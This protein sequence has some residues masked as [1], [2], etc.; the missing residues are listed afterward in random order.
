MKRNGL[1]NR[2]TTNISRKRVPVSNEQLTWYFDNIE[3][4][5]ILSQESPSV[6]WM[7]KILILPAKKIPFSVVK[8]RQLVM[9]CLLMRMRMMRKPC[10]LTISIWVIL[11]WSTDPFRIFLTGVW[12]NARTNTVWCAMV[13]DV[14]FTFSKIL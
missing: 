6:I 14:Y 13:C 12:Q 5:L 3:R 10:I 4:D 2:I 9:I 8:V 1:T 7:C 11:Q